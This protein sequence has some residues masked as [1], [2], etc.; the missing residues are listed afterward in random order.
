MVSLTAWIAGKFDS[1]H[2]A[3]GGFGA[4][5]WGA[6]TISGVSFLAGRVVKPR[7]F[8]RAFTG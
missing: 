7:R 5:F 6:V 2:S 3:I 4:A 1:L 8:S